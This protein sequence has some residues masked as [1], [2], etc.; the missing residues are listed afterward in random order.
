MDNANKQIVKSVKPLLCEIR[1]P[2]SE[3][4]LR[5]ISYTVYLIDPR[6][7]GYLHF[8]LTKNFKLEI[9]NPN[10][11]KHSIVHQR[12]YAFNRHAGSFGVRIHF[13]SDWKIVLEP[14]AES[15]V[16]FEKISV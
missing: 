5:K 6:F 12:Y 9:S 11:P 2:F 15:W 10:P 4:G 1:G 16:N 3:S 7:Q 13:E 8:G 14:G